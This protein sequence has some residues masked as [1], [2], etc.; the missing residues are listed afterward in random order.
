[1]TRLVVFISRTIWEK[2]HFYSLRVAIICTA[3]F[4]TLY[5]QPVRAENWVV[6]WQ[7]GEDGQCYDRDSLFKDSRGFQHYSWTYAATSRGQAPSQTSCIKGAQIISVQEVAV[8]CTQDMSGTI[9]LYHRSITTMGKPS[10]EKW[11][12]WE[13]DDDISSDDPLW[14]LSRAVCGLSR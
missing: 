11:T 8:D 13:L 6:A 9:N 7:S 14:H 2:N 3:M 1:M 10:L 4:A 5:A 12:N